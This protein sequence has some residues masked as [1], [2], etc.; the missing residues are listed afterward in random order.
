[1]GEPPATDASPLIFL[2]RADRL[3][4]LRLSS[5]EVVVPTPV[6]EEI[7]RRGPADATA[8]ALNATPWLRVVDPP[9]TPPGVREWDL[10]PGESSV[11]AWCFAHSGA[12]AIIDDLQDD[13]APR[14]W[15]SLCAERWASCSSQS[16]EA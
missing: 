1:V 14:G 12:E 15:A 5:P 9:P 10:G 2:A 11:L 16:S 7:S 4:F 6:A 8:R 3:D 13:A